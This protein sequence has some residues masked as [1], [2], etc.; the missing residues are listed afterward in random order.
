MYPTLEFC[1]AVVIA[2][3][4]L[5]VC[6]VCV[7]CVELVT[8]MQEEKVVEVRARGVQYFDACYRYVHDELH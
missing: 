8:T 5:V 3:A 6:V 4:V 7:V 1:V 2:V